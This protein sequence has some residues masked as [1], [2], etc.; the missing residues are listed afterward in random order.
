[1]KDE[2]RKWKLHRAI[3]VLM[4]FFIGCDEDQYTPVVTD[5]N[6]AIL[7]KWEITHLGQGIVEDPIAYDEYLA[8]SVLLVYN[9]Q[10]K[11]FWKYRYWFADSLLFKSSTNIAYDGAEYDTIVTT[12]PYRY[13]FLEA[14]KLKLEF[15]YP[16]IF[17]TSIYKRIRYDGRAGRP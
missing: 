2:K 9:Y 14:D 5:P 12:F 16:A 7:G 15:Q 1:M 6:K 17:R 10:E 3:F 11:T 8:D 13:E 4:V